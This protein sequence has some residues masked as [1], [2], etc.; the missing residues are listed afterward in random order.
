MI[1]TDVTLIETA[2]ACCTSKR[3]MEK[4]CNKRH[5]YNDKNLLNK[6]VSESENY[7][8]DVQMDNNLI[9][10]NVAYYLKAV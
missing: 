4:S 9:G 10:Y 8:Y 6:R 3:R 7:R 5:E 2:T 1:D